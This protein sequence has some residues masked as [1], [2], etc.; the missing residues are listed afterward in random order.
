ME[1]RII[2]ST[3]VANNKGSKIPNEVLDFDARFRDN[4]VGFRNHDWE[5]DPIVMWKDWRLEF[6]D[7]IGMEG[8]TAV[9]VFHELDEASR[10]YK[11]MYEKGFLRTASIG[12]FSTYKTDMFGQEL[13]DSDGCLVSTHFE[14]Y[15]ISLPSLPSNPKAFQTDPLVLSAGDLEKIEGPRYLEVDETGKLRARL[16][17]L[18]T[19]YKQ[20]LDAMADVKPTP[21]PTPVDPNAPAVPAAQSQKATNAAAPQEPAKHGTDSLPEPVA[22]LVKNKRGMKLAAALLGGTIANILGLSADDGPEGDPAP[23]IEPAADPK[24]HNPGKSVAK[25]QPDPIGLAAEK[26][27]KAQT[28]L[29][30]AQTNLTTKLE[31]A[32]AAK[33]K[34]EK[35]EATDEEKEEYAAAQ[36]DCEAAMKDCEKADHEVHEAED[37]MDEMKTGKKKETHSAGQPG[38]GSKPVLVKMETFKA[39]ME[40]L[41]TPPAPNPNTLGGGKIIR[42]YVGKT[43]TQLRAS[44]E[45]DANDER[46]LGRI[47]NNEST[48]I[49]D[50]RAVFGSM[51]NDPRLKP[52]LSRARFASN[53]SDEGAERIRMSPTYGRDPRLFTTV[54]QFAAQVASGNIEYLAADRTVKKMT[55][56][57]SSDAALA[58]PALN[59]IAFLELVFFKLFPSGEWKSQIP[60]LAPTILPDNTGVIW[61]NIL[62]DPTIYVGNQPAT[63][64]DY[65]YGDQGVSMALVPYW[66]QPMRWTPL[67]MHQLRYDQ[68]STGLAQGFAKMNARIDDALIY[69][70]LQAV[71]AA[72]ILQT[73]GMPSLLP[74]NNWSS[75]FT[76]PAPGSPDSFLFAP[77]F[78]GALTKPVVND[79]AV[80]EQLMYKQNFRMNSEKLILVCDPTMYKY[81]MQD[82]D[83]KN[84]LGRFTDADGSEIYGYG[85]TR[86]VK[87]SQVG[88]YVPGTGVIDP[89]GV[90]PASAISIA[91]GFIASQVALGI[92][93]MD[94]FQVQDPT[95]YGM[96]VSADVRMGAAAMWYQQRGM[97]GYTYAPGVIA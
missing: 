40:A 8:W 79:A 41:K 36:R 78:T 6:I 1:R 55:A 38:P 56:L 44:S 23:S 39:R 2:V 13:K 45:K 97:L 54:E 71:P 90:V 82:P 60:I 50:Y 35:P 65:T 37:E 29:G 3:P 77:N 7:S 93:L 47:S 75:S 20:T 14:V 30:T 53:I 81:F 95:N 61:G 74:A 89:Y 12:G 64:A 4:P 66:L 96:K 67:T 58:A 9:P 25:V 42:D 68:E 27:E 69:T 34:A 15:E 94:V 88:A 52:I 11:A 22:G 24:T 59:A 92:G 19:K 70:L 73:T 5:S 48:D 10:K 43:F 28:A 49:A 83:A 51:L 21:D 32:E 33:K 46:L 17:V 87:R 16:L 76:I 86:F 57:S 85:N 31:K 26:L 18:S 62:A 91:L 80:M 72:S 63:P 84:L